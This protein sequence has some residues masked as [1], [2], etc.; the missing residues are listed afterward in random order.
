MKRITIVFIAIAVVL[1]VNT[2]FASD[3]IEFPYGTTGTL[4]GK[5]I[6]KATKEPLPGAQVIVT[7]TKYGAAA[8]RNGFFIINN[9]PAGVY[10][11]KCTMISYATMIVEKVTIIMDQRTTINFTM[12]EQPI[13]GEEI[14]I[15]A[16]RPLIQPDITSSSHFIPVANIQRLP[17]ED[18]QQ[19]VKL[20][21]GVV[22]GH[23][24]GGRMTEV[25]YMVDGIPVQQAL[26]GGR[27]T[28]LPNNSIIELTVQ[29]GGFNAEYGKAM[30]GVVNVVTKEGTDNTYFYGLGLDDRLGNFVNDKGYD[31]Y[32]RFEMTLSGPAFLVFGF[33]YFISADIRLTDTRYRPAF[34]DYPN[35]FRSPVSANYNTNI[36]ISKNITNNIKIVG[37]GLISRWDWHEYEHRWVRNL[38]GIPEREK[39]S[40]R[41]SLNLTHTLNSKSYYTLSL[42]RF[43]V[44]QSI[45]GKKSDEYYP[46][47]LEIPW[48]P[49]SYVLSGDKQWWQD[50][51]EITSMA[52]LDWI[53]QVN[54]SHQIKAGVEFTYY[55]L[56]VNDV[57]Y[58]EIPID[59]TKNLLGY[60]V[61]NNQYRYF[62]KSGSA[63]LQD[64]IEYEGFV[65]NIGGR[66]D[67]F[68]PTATRPAAE[69]PAKDTGNLQ[70][71]SEIKASVKYQFSPRI[72]ITFP[73]SVK[74]KIHMNYGWFF[75]MPL[76]QYLYTNLDYDF[77][78]YWPL[79]GNPDMQAEK[80]ISYEAGYKRILSENMVV[81]VTAFN[82]DITNLADTKTYLLPDSTIG[83]SAT[84]RGY[85]EYVN[86]AYGHATGIECVLEKRMS[87]WFSGKLSYTFMT[88]KG[89]SSSAGQG[90]NWLVWGVNVPRNQEYALSWDQRHTVIAD[91]SIMKK[92]D[93]N[94]N[95]LYQL[96]SPL[97]W[98]KVEDYKPNNQRMGWR[99]NLDFKVIKELH[100]FRNRFN[101]NVYVEGLNLFNN[102]NLL[103][104]D[105]F[106]N[107]G[108]KLGD[109][110]AW[111]PDRRIRIG[112]D[113]KL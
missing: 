74:E 60:N 109:P 19:V 90:Y 21:P 106:G 58:E 24:R 72:G 6:D 13:E 65:A 88:A 83:G 73:I 49:T 51:R 2:V 36:K 33:K 17:I 108:G 9:I 93:W 71:V 5:I 62:P 48:D 68:D 53:N 103:W 40:Y 15:T 35:R 26:Q 96:N 91:V 100:L 12:K 47:T 43:N 16:E 56:Y 111:D 104:K 112:M 63:Y 14:V 99:Q 61:Y 64:K 8:D 79:V 3:G 52:K 113:M 18:F 22:A 107:N 78:G 4:A 54:I 85:A 82:K 69:I 23:V 97:P 28:A 20:Q 27:G 41:L 38:N 87:G 25:L 110:S 98:T 59:S 84:R 76:F 1:I 70:K 50:N 75:Q 42:S 10:K 11:I 32:K 94:I 92:D 44:L 34:F 31:N 80:T 81:S 89:S 66:F 57:Q 45:L 102:K 30:S 29:T 37:Q 95:L 7:G 67:F 86:L 77:Q 55:D 105:S 101:A 39:T 46:V